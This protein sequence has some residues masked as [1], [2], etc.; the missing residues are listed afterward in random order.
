MMQ[1]VMLPE[2]RRARHVRALSETALIEHDL[3]WLPHG[4]PDVHRCCGHCTW[5]G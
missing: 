2:E 1:E 5:T 3:G 4:D